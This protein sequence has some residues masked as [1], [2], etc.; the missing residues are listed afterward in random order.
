[1]PFFKCIYKDLLTNLNERF[2]FPKRHSWKPPTYQTKRIFLLFV[3]DAPMFL[4]QATSVLK[5][6]T[7]GVKFVDVVKMV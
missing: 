4:N 7:T 6:L 2:F 1:M 3:I 5:V